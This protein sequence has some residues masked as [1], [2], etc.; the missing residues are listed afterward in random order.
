ML[1]STQAILRT[2]GIELLFP[3]QVATY[4]KVLAGGDMIGRAKTGQGKT[5]AFVLPIVQR[6]LS[7]E[8]LLVAGRAPRVLVRSSA[9]V[10]P[11]LN[12]PVCPSR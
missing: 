12:L 9:R 8:Q 10:D 2:R 5:L 1:E 6:L 11:L 4:A 3:I 7:A